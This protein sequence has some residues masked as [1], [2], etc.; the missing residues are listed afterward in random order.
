MTL[1]MPSR[2]GYSRPSVAEDEE[3]V[4]VTKS[5]CRNRIPAARTFAP[6][7]CFCLCASIYLIAYYRGLAGGAHSRDLNWISRHIPVIGFNIALSMAAFTVAVWTLLLPTAMSRQAR[8]GSGVGLVGCHLIYLL[9]D[10]GQDFQY[11]G[12]YN[13]MVFLLMWVPVNMVLVSLYGLWRA[14]TPKRFVAILGGLGAALSI[15]CGIMLVHYRSLVSFESL[16]SHKWPLR[17]CCPESQQAMGGGI[18][19]S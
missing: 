17:R 5:G 19:A 13:W 14:T 15:I 10:G 7:A 1:R 6:Y 11:H 18:D 3:K 9:Y 12:F 2:R 4:L 16:K 8:W